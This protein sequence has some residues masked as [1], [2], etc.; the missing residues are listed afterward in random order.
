MI[1]CNHIVFFMRSL[2]LQPTKTL[3]DPEIKA[4]LALG[5]KTKK[6]CGGKKKKVIHWLKLPTAV[7]CV[8]AATVFRL[9]NFGQ[10]SMS[11]LYQISAIN[12]DEGVADRVYLSLLPTSEGSWVTAARALRMSLV[13]VGA[14]HVYAVEASEMAE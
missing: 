10:V 11:I 6:K 3:G 7:S 8:F 4:W 1:C 14:K 9:G 5:T 13:L 12:F 2:E